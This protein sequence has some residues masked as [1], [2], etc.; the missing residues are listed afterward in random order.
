MLFDNY[1]LMVETAGLPPR[2]PLTRDARAAILFGLGFRGRERGAMSGQVLN[3]LIRRAVSDSEFR[4]K[5]TDP[6]RFAE[7]VKG[8][9]LTPEEVERLRRVTAEKSS[10]HIPFADGLGERLSK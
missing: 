9:D 5:L 3:E 1:P 10:V 2:R 6:A 7:A 8:L 4:K